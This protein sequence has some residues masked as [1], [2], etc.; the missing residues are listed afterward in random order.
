MSKKRISALLMAAVMAASYVLPQTVSAAA[1]GGSDSVNL[2]WQINGSDVNVSRIGTDSHLLKLE[3]LNFG[4]KKIPTSDGVLNIIYDSR[5]QNSTRQYSVWTDLSGDG[6]EISDYSFAS[7]ANRDAGKF[8]T[9]K[10]YSSGTPS[11]SIDI[12][13]ELLYNGTDIATTLY[14]LIHTYNPASD[15]PANQRGGGTNLEFDRFNKISLTGTLTGSKWGINNGD[16][17]VSRVGTDNHVIKLSNLDFG[18]NNIPSSGGLLELNYDS[19]GQNST[20]Q[21]SVWTDLSGDS[22][23]INDYSFASPANRDDGKIVT[24]KD[25]ASGTATVGIEIPLELLYDGVNTASEIYVNLHVYNPASDLPDNQRGGGTKLEF[26]R[27]DNITLTDVSLDKQYSWGLNPDTADVTRTGTD[28]HVIKL[29]NIG[30]TRADI[31]FILES[32]AITLDIMYGSSGQNS[33]RQYSVWTD[34]SGD[35]SEVGDYTFASPANRDAGKLVTSK[36]YSAGTPLVSIDIPKELIYDGTNIASEIY[37]T[38]H[39]YNPASDLPD[40][41]RGGGTKLEFD[42]L[43]KIALNIPCLSEIILTEDTFTHITLTPGADPSMMGFA[44]FTEKG[45]TS[46]SAVQVTAK[47]NLVDGKMP[48]GA[49]KFYGTNGTGTSQY[50]TNKA[51]ATG[52]VKNTEYAYRVGDSNNWSNVYTFKTYDQDGKYNVIVVADPQISAEDDYIVW[53]DTVAKAV[54]KAGGASF[55]MSAGD[56]ANYSNDLAGMEDYLSPRELLNLPVMAAVGNHD[57]DFKN[58]LE[59]VA[60]LSLLYNW[61]NYDDLTDKTTDLARI[62]GGGDYYFSYGNTLYI[63]INSFA[64]NRT[65]DIHRTFMEEAIASHPDAVWKVVLFHHDI[66]GVGD[67]AGIGYGDSAAMQATWSPFLDEFGIDIAFN[68]HDHIYARSMFMK[69]NEIMKY[70]MPAVL[71]VNENSIYKENAGVYI[72]PDG[73][74]YMA[75]ATAGTKFYNPEMQ[76]WVAYTPGRLDVPEYTIMS[77]DGD[78]LTITT[79]RTD[80]NK[81]TDSITI[82]KKALFS[83]LQSLISGSESLTRGDTT[84]ASWNAFQNQIITAKAVSSSASAADIHQAYLDLYAKYYALEVPTVKSD[85]ND[86]INIV[87]LKLA[88]ASEGKWEGQYPA[89]SKATL[90]AV[91]DSA[92]I[93]R[94]LRLSTQSEVDT[95][96]TELKNAYDLFESLVSDIPIPWTFV[97]EIKSS[98]KTTVDLVDWMTESEIYFWGNDAQERYDSSHIKQD[99][100]GS[101]ADSPRSEPLYGPANASGGRGHNNAHITKTHIGEW[102][103]YEL[104]VESAGMY[105][106]SIG[107]ANSTAADQK[108]LIRDTEHH[109]LGTFVIPANSTL[110]ADGWDN[111]AIIGADKEIY[112]PKGSYVIELFFVNDGIPVSTRDNNL[113]PNGAEIDILTFER[114]GDGTAPVYTKDKSI[115]ALPTPNTAAGAANRQRGWGSEGYEDEWG[116]IASGISLDIWMAATQLVLEMPDKP[117]STN[118]Q[119]QLV[120]DSD[121]YYWNQ[122]EGFDFNKMYAD[123]KLT[124]DFADLKGFDAFRA[125]KE[126]CRLIISYYGNGFD[127]LNIMNAYLVLDLSLLKNPCSLGH[128]P[129]TDNCTVCSECGDTTLPRSCTESTPCTFHKPSENNPGTSGGGTYIPTNTVSDNNKAEPDTAD[130]DIEFDDDIDDDIDD[131]NEIGNALEDDEPYIIISDDED[132]IL[133]ADTLK[134]IRKSGKTITIEL[135]NGV[136]VTIDGSTISKN[137]TSLDLNMEVLFGNEIQLIGDVQIPENAI[138]ISPSAHGKFGLELSIE[139]SAEMLLE[140]GLDPNNTSLFYIDDDGMVTDLGK[141]TVN[142]DGSVTIKLTHA[143]SYVLAESMQAGASEDVKDENPKTSVTIGFTGLLLAGGAAVILR[144]KK[145]K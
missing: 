90:K 120:T 16:T 22:S 83:D 49:S 129:K 105:K 128:T 115:Y 62:V 29:E 48:D 55:L 34:L 74:Q 70:Q 54:A 51:T 42:R 100:A 17:D 119:I 99:F 59:E 23:D 7:P 35:A 4:S 52:L 2:E 12:P 103:R 101:D 73:I 111:A 95:S 8:V 134:Q 25:Y 79:Y 27:L 40:N 85:L 141:V 140:A 61:P 109:V 31:P 118:L 1:P 102:I 57:N 117:A 18:P 15:L 130:D 75:L 143:S 64:D 144:K 77:I 135:P 28:S 114:T 6:S 84:D 58:G 98:E 86:L 53:K 46:T 131:G 82:R 113:Y 125:T 104:D 108:I 9:S 116:M 20:R 26:D 33:T 69:N 142:A 50:D 63:T 14:V 38:I 80:T 68:G 91:L 88:A 43:N 44:W 65:V 89:G 39:V 71:D 36:D 78:S 37:V 45:T 122:T 138:I 133:S 41:Q 30:I 76:P 136:K 60:L 96:F 97:H 110:P 126:E 3:G 72:Q 11:I 137:A 124:F 145:T 19:R 81:Q 132:T 92:V 47:A 32:P 5:G 56:Q 123:G 24:S 107:A 67:H 10:D 66:Y 112:L 127:E 139:I 106:V 93:I 121:D 87:S 21:Y 13:N 94:D